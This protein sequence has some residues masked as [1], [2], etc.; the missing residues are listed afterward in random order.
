MACGKFFVQTGLDILVYRVQA[1]GNI[2]QLS[3]FF[4]YQPLGTIR[5]PEAIVREDVP[6]VLRKVARHLSAL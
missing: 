4:F 1:A 2:A 5:I 6:L 3:R